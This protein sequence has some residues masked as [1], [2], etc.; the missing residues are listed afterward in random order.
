MLRKQN[1]RMSGF[2]PE[3]P[4]PS[5]LRWGDKPLAHGPEESTLAVVDAQFVQ[6]PPP[7]L[8]CLFVGL[9]LVHLLP[10]PA[11]NLMFLNPFCR[12]E[13]ILHLGARCVGHISK[14]NHIQPQ[15]AM[16]E[17]F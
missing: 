16:V 14:C 4:T 8:P 7:H 13:L 12:A 10:I 11:T 15:L 3:G 1:V 2:D 6:K 5:H 17:S 9:E